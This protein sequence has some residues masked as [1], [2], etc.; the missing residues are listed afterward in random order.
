MNEENKTVEPVTEAPKEKPAAEVAAPNESKKKGKGGVLIVLLILVLV[1]FAV[2]F[3]VLGGNEMLGLKKTPKEPNQGQT[4][5][6]KPTEK[7]IEEVE[8]TSSEV[9]KALNNFEMIDISKEE[10][11]KDGLYNISS[12]SFKQKIETLGRTV[13][14]ND[15]TKIAYCANEFE[16]DIT[17][18]KINEY[19]G[20][21][22]GISVTK[23]ELES[24]GSK[25]TFQTLENKVSGIHVPGNGLYSLWIVDGKYYVR[26]EICDGGGI[27]DI[28]YKKVI[29]AEKDDSNLYVY[30]KRAFYDLGNRNEKG[31]LVKVEVKYYKDFAKTQLVETL[32]G[33]E[34]PTINSYVEQKNEITWDSYSTYK[35]TFKIKNGNYYFE[36]YELVK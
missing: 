25:D 2:W 27:D 15:S 34:V 33:T 1:I 4:E 8:I 17:L 9:T 28:L 13:S 24:N 11:T 36:K 23:E 6:P 10:L 30:E 31:E 21:V 26:N 14:S 20:M 5:D 18:E 35:Y 19:L 7:K 22:L 3:F 12:L 16:N 29:K 32:E